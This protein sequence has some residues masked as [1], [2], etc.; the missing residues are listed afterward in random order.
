M[1]KLEPGTISIAL[2][3]LVRAA[4]D[5]G[6][7]SRRCEIVADTIVVISSISVR[8]KILSKLRKVGTFSRSRVDCEI[9]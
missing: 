4:A 8:G 3:E 9:Y 7:G 2:D 6:I 5:G 1:A